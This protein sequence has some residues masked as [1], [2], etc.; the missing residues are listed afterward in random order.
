[1][2]IGY[3]LRT[4]LAG[5]TSDYSMVTLP[6]IWLYKALQERLVGSILQCEVSGLGG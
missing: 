6:T 3:Y 4:N 2:M 5:F 1:M